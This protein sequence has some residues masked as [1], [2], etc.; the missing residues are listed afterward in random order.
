MKGLDHA[1]SRVS[2]FDMS[3][4]EVEYDYDT[5]SEQIATSKTMLQTD[6]RDAIEWFIMDDPLNIVFN[7]TN[8]DY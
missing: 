1:N 5:E 2:Q 6:L 8:P 4:L 3:K 7:L